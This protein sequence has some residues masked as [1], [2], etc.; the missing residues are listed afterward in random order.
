MPRRNWQDGMEIVYE[1]LNSISSAMERL[2]FDRSV[3]QMMQQTEDAFFNDG[4]LVEYASSS[5][6]TVRAGIGHQT[7][8]SQVSPE[9]V[10]R[11][12]HKAA[13]TTHDITTPDGSL[14][15]ID[16]LVVKAAI[17]TE[18]SGTRK[19]KDAA[20][21]TISN[22]TMVLQK[23]W[24][25]DVEF[26]LGTPGGVPVAPSTPVGY[27]KIAELYVTAASGL[28]G[29]GAVTDYRTLMPVGGDVKIDTSALSRITTGGSTTIDTIIA[30]IDALLKNGYQEYTDFDDLAAHPGN[31]AAS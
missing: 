7:D 23:D 15:R 8:S 26:V 10:K 19:Y 16:L 24:E 21:S 29:A 25:S 20:T 5:S 31:P 3:F 2:L 17:E 18:L 6:V 28:A 13:Q 22:Q 4:F 9:P 27:L 30:D 12:L 14:D 1:D 11:L